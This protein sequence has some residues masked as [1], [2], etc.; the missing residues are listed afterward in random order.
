MAPLRALVREGCGA[1]S[2]IHREYLA[3][4]GA[5]GDGV[6]GCA[7]GQ[8]ERRQPDLIARVD[9]DARQLLGSETLRRDLDRVGA[10]VEVRDGEYATLVGLR[11]TGILRGIVDNSD[12]RAQYQRAR[13]VRYRARYRSEERRVG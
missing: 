6:G 12:R 4:D 1:L 9:F 8:D 10:G 7:D 11:R 3:G 5:H 2:V 13:G